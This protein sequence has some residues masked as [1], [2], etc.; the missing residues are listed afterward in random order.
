MGDSRPFLLNSPYRFPLRRQVEE[1]NT[2]KL[3]ALA[4]E[5]LFFVA[6]DSG[7][8]K[9]KLDQHCIAPT[10]L[11]IKVGA[12]VMLLRN[13]NGGTGGLVNGSIG[14]VIEYTRD[15]ATNIQLGSNGKPLPSL[16][17]VHELLPRVKFVLEGGRESVMVVGREEWSMELPDGEVVARRI[18][19]PL[20]LAWSLSIHKAQGQTLPKVRVD[21]ARVFEKGNPSPSFTPSHPI[22]IID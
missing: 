15:P 4:S 2:A 3:Y 5:S 22:L 10:K 9:D 11:E 20:C 7:M 1:A 19:I 8:L 12:Q 21:L 13:Q 18:Q 17:T 6:R 16:N 14:L